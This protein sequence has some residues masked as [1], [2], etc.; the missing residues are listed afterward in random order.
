LAAIS[1]SNVSN[2]KQ[3]MIWYWSWGVDADLFKERRWTNLF[4]HQFQTLS[5]YI[6]FTYSLT[7][8]WVFQ[9]GKRYLLTRNNDSN[10]WM[11]KSTMSLLASASFLV[12]HTNNEERLTEEGAELY[13]KVSPSI[14]RFFYNFTTQGWSESLMPQATKT[15]RRIQAI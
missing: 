8:F 12:I 3:K 15:R 14:F 2:H 11:A 5:V 6:S 9:I 13:Y 4:D 10:S 7:V 1:F